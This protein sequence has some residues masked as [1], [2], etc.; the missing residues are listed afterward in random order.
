MDPELNSKFRWGD[1]VRIDDAAPVQLR[2]GSLAAV[3]AIS[4]SPGQIQYTV[5]FG[6]GTDAEVP[7]SLVSS[8]ISEH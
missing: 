8:D 5:E 2:P 3:V 7:E 6:D 1:T 4:G